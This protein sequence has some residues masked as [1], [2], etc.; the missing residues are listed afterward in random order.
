M[1]D[2]EDMARGALALAGVALAEGDLA[3]LGIVAQAFEPG[4]RLLDGANLAELPLEG[5]LDPARPPRP[6]PAAGAD[7]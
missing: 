3:V 4:V 7:A 1:D 6:S 2:F 5:D